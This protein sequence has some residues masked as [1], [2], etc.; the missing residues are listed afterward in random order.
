[1]PHKRNPIVSERLTG[2]ARLLRGYAQT[3]LENVALWH[4]R[5]I[6]HSSNERVTLADSTTLLHYMLVRAE[7][8][9]KGL[10][11]NERAVQA[12]LNRG[13]GVMMSS[14][15]LLALVECG[16]TREEAYEIVQSLSFQA[17]EG[18]DFR[19]LLQASPQAGPL[20]ADR[21]DEIFD[22]SRSLRHGAAIL[23]GVKELL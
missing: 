17:K 3:G 10:V 14:A 5:D 4:E 13:G 9:A 22:T 7:G 8:V 20:L 16:M 2:Q 18:G 15:A 21:M 6:S 23:K 12:N 11:V 19:A 1:M